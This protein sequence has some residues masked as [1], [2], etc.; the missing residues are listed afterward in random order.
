MLEISISD[1][2][3]TDYGRRVAIEVDWTKLRDLERRAGELVARGKVRRQD[4]SPLPAEVGEAL[5]AYLS[6]GWHPVDAVHLFLTCRAPGVHLSRAW[7]ADRAGASI[8]ALNLRRIHRNDR[9]LGFGR[10][11]RAATAPIAP[12]AHAH[13]KPGQ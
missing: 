6:A 4:R 8:S 12:H 2:K 5:V 11:A 1:A 13:E 3:T 9:R 10:V 7:R